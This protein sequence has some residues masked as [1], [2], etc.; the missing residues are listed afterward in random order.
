MKNR[1]EPKVYIPVKHKN[2]GIVGLGLIGGSLALALKRKSRQYNIVGVD[3]SADALEYAMSEGIVNLG[4]TDLKILKGCE[5]IFVA[6]D[7][8]QVGKVIGEVYAVVGKS[9]IITDAASI[10]GVIEKGL[11]EG[12]RFVG[13]HPMAGS[14]KGGIRE[15]KAH[16][17]ENARYF[18]A[19]PGYVSESDYD[20]VFSLV[21]AIG[22][23]PCAVS[24]E[25]HD[26]IASAVSH[27]PHMAAFA[28]CHAAVRDVEYARAAG[29]GLKDMTRV[30]ASQPDFWVNVAR[31]NKSVLLD[32]LDSYQEILGQVREMIAG[33]RDAELKEFFQEAAEKRAQIDS[34][35][36]VHFINVDV[37]DR[38]NAIARVTRILGSRDI[39]IKN[40]AI[41]NSREG[42]GG[43][44]LIAFDSKE[45]ASEAEK[46]LTKKKYAVSR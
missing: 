41:L 36:A 4:S 46:L 9:A 39:N 20:E 29:G 28:L 2:I 13:G 40:I 21:S 22:A 5:V 37:A 10:K 32:S 25:E 1:F 12:I 23:I 18:L 43:A 30:A 19:K 26:R 11:P 7:V 27:L 17:F 15:A 3:R 42:A 14:E 31:L 35:S 6:T 44:L 38:P 33:G 24:A 34:P 45:G 16:L 8:D